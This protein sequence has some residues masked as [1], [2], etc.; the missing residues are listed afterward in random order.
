M[1]FRQ[2]RISIYNNR[3]YKMGTIETIQAKRLFED[4]DSNNL[5]KGQDKMFDTEWQFME[6]KN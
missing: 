3:K 5:Q 6:I 1:V 2:W 4:L